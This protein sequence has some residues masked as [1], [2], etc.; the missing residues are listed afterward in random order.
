MM[1]HQIKPQKSTYLQVN[2]YEELVETQSI[3]SYFSQN[4]STIFVWKTQKLF[5]IKILVF[6]SIYSDSYRF[7]ILR[8]SSV[9]RGFH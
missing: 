6:F 4:Y 7:Y 3:N 5:L 1:L 8:K 9:L 2:A